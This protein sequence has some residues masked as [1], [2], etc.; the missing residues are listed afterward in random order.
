MTYE[1]T[2][3]EKRG[4]VNGQIRNVLFRKYGA[5]VELISENAVATPNAQK[6]S[7]L[8]NEIEKCE[9]Q[10]NALTTELESL[11]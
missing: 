5:E 6:V 1:L 2:L 7:D 11:V 8:N 3:D 4:I 9:N 10:Y